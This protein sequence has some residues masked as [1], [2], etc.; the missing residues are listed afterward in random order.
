M[1]IALVALGAALVVTNAFWLYLY[2]DHA[3]SSANHAQV[4]IEDK[5]ALSQ[6]LA[7]VRLAKG[8]NARAEIV[9]AAR[10]AL[11]NSGA[12][13]E[14]DGAVHVGRLALTFDAKG[15]FVDAQQD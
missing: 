2:V 7:I 11:A 4:C 1:K 3:A 9:D 6:A 15:A 12:P 10:R 13:F 5:E 8:R 14:K